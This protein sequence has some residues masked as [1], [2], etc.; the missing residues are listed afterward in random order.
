MS[1]KELLQH[2]L[3]V[4]GSLVLDSKQ[5]D[6]RVRFFVAED[7]FA[8][9]LVVRDEN[10]LFPFG[11]TQDLIV[12]QARVFVVHRACVVAKASKP[13][14][15]VG[16]RRFVDEKAHLL[17]VCQ[18]SEGVVGDGLG[19]EKQARLNVFPGQPPVFAQ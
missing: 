9:V 18:R 15:N 11:P 16:S 10:S 2:G 3:L 7:Q 13:A 17:R 5:D 14:S 8:E 1:L 6:S 12:S 19:S 4:R